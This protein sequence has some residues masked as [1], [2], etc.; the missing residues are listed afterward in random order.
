MIIRFYRQFCAAVTLP[1]PQQATKT[2][3]EECQ[4]EM[5]L[6]HEEVENAAC[7]LSMLKCREQRLLAALGEPT[8]LRRVQ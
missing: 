2:K 6:A 7:K 5:L 1:S 8:Q 3:L 4:R